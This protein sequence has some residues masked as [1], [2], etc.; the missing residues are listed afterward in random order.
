M[1]SIILILTTIFFICGGAHRGRIIGGENAAIEDY[2]YQVSIQYNDGFH[3][4]GGS[5]YKPNVIITAAHCVF[6]LEAEKIHIRA[7]SNNRNSGGVIVT[8]KEI[9]PSENWNSQTIDNDIA[10]LILTEN[11]Q[12][13]DKIQPI[14]IAKQEP[15]P[16]KLAYSVG[17]G[18]TE[19]NGKES[20]VI[21]QAISIP[22]WERN[23]CNKLVKARL[24]EN[25]MCAGVKQAG[26]SSCR[27]DSGGG[28][29][30]DGKLVGVVSWGEG[31]GK[32]NS[33]SVFANV[34]KYIS[35]IQSKLN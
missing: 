8:V 11:L 6:G 13:S 4:C 15:Q 2:P 10:I 27:M 19:E 31:C 5:I 22:I 1:K 26:K 9:I 23:D 25:M 34:P 14:E 32:Y 16:G 24:T 33:P 7:G 28:L 12:Y 29:A 30:V 35:W 17:W 20:P 18:L 21:L 3:F